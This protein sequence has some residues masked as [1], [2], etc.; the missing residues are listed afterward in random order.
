[1]TVLMMRICVVGLSIAAA[2]ALRLGPASAETLWLNANLH[3]ADPGLIVTPAAGT[4]SIRIQSSLPA[5]T[6][7]IEFP[8]VVPTNYEI[9]SVELC[10]QL[11]DPGTFVSQIRV[12]EMRTPDFRSVIKDDGTDRT[13]QGPICIT[14]VPFFPRPPNGAIMVSLR[15]DFED[16]P[17][18]VQIAGIGLNFSPSLVAVEE[19]V[20]PADLKLLQNYPNPFASSTSIEFRVPEAGDV[21]LRVYKPTGQHGGRAAASCLGRE[22]QC[23]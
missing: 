8:A 13:D 4:G 2:I 14:S 3:I 19:G 17:D 15:I 12:T 22:E 16:E 18:W 9:S 10:Y 1:M 5:V 6:R 21:E 7:W 20:V 23:R 11:S